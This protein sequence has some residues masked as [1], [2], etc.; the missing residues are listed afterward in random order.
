[1]SHAAKGESPRTR[2]SQ[3]FEWYGEDYDKIRYDIMENEDVR[4]SMQKCRKTKE[5]I[6]AP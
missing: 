6:S 2:K 1:M 3:V 5:A 4:R